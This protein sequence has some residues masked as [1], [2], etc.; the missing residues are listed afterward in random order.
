[1]RVRSISALVLVAILCVVAGAWWRA[2]AQGRA[3]AG[4]GGSDAWSQ[5]AATLKSGG[6][7][8]NGHHRYAF[9]RRDLQVKVGDVPIEPELALTSWVGFAGDPGN[10]VM[11]GDL[12]LLDRELGPVLAAL[13]PQQIDVNA[14]HDHLSGEEPRLIYVH[15]HGHGDALT[16]AKGLDQALALTGTPRPVVDPPPQPVT[17]DTAKVFGTLGGKGFARGNVA[18]ITFLF[19]PG[20]VTM[21]GVPVPPALGYASPVTVEQIAPNRMVATGD[22]AT[23]ADKVPD[24]VRA[25]ST[26]GIVATALHTHM[27]GETPTVYFTHFWGDGAPD[28]VLPGLKA[29]LDAAH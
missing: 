13:A 27:V 19:I 10:A 24:L 17:I 3:P 29:V 4:G 21:D 18:G 23:T 12:V 25:M 26:H 7:F 20:Q 15:V 2:Q 8:V 14:I 11:M 5:V 16:L 28:S 6:A 22:I 1:M 9:P